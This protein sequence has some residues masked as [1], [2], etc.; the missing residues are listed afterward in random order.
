MQGLAADMA[1]SNATDT[2]A[3]GPAAMPY[4]AGASSA[5]QHPEP[6]TGDTMPVIKAEELSATDLP[7]Q[8]VKVL[9]A[10]TPAGSAV[11]TTKAQPG[12]A[13]KSGSK[14]WFGKAGGILG[15]WAVPVRMKKEPRSKP[16]GVMEETI[17]LT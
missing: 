17:D 11:G 9:E 13:Q 14:A 10:A 1:Q 8:E 7:K 2:S 3:T 4:T 12:T 15:R 16:S 5:M 6:A